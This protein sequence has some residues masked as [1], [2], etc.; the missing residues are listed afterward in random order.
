M[1][2]K[3]FYFVPMRHDDPV[4]KPN[5]LVA[6]FDLLAPAMEAAMDAKQMQPLFL[7]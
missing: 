4:K 7:S 5:S 1:N 6:R 3:H 2:M